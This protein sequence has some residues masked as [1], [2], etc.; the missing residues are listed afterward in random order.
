MSGPHRAVNE[1]RNSLR[2]AFTDLSPGTRV[3]LAVSGGADSLAMALAAHYATRWTGIQL[4]AL[5]IDHGLRPESAH[6]ATHVLQ[7]LAEIGID[8]ES[9]KVEVSGSA[10]PEGNARTARYGALATRARELA[11]PAGVPATVALGHTAAD[12][13]ETVLMGLARGSG[14]RSISG[15]RERGS[16]PEHPDVPMIRPLLEH[17][18]QDLET[19][20]RELGYSWIRDPSNE[21][22][23]PWRAA[24]GSPLRRAAVRAH[25]LPALQ[26]ALGPGVVDALARTATLLQDDDDALSAIAQDVFSAVA[27]KPSGEPKTREGTQTGPALDCRALATHPPAVRRR[28]LKLAMDH[29]GVRGGELK[30]WHV[31]RLDKLVESRDNKLGIDLP[32]ARA[33]RVDNILYFAHRAS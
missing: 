5:H 20:C 17:S 22:H 7:Q 26:E 6:E 19:V 8:A 30:Y 14:A 16:L 33:W 2:R 3:I 32:G 1:A 31:V 10:G 4:S 11:N 18:R 13:A 27:V 15:M 21:P 25:A 9:V 12:Q 29:V 24:D 23:G 28:V